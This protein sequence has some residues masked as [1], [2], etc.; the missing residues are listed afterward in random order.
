M[1]RADTSAL[2][3]A[4]KKSKTKTFSDKTFFCRSEGNVQG[5]KQVNRT[6]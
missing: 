5:V 2:N 4:I 1:A 3:V 6:N